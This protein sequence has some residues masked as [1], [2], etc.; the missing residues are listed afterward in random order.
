MNK[1]EYYLLSGWAFL[2]YRYNTNLNI[3]IK[4][5]SGNDIYYYR[6]G[7]LASNDSMSQ[8]AD[9]GFICLIDKRT[10]QLPSRTY[11][12]ALVLHHPVNGIQA[13]YEL[14]RELKL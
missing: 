7:P 12:M 1:N 10:T 2:K 8:E 5:T 6:S 4:L 13:T 11:E 9:N 14:D 3:Y